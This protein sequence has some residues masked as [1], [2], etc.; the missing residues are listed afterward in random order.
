MVKLL[1][2]VARSVRGSLWTLGLSSLLAVGCGGDAKPPAAAPG[3]AQPGATGAPAAHADAHHHDHDLPSG[4]VPSPKLIDRRARNAV[5]S[6]S[7][8]VARSAA[9]PPKTEEE[10]YRAVAPATVIVRVP[11]GLGSGVIIDPAG[12][13]LTNHHVVEHGTSE[14]FRT[15]VGIVLGHLDKST[16]GMERDKKEYT[17]WV[18]KDDKLRDLALVK[19]ENP[20]KNL[21]FVPLSKTPPVPGEHVIAIGHAGAGM[22]WAIK[23]GEISALGKLSEHLATLAQFKDDDSGKKAEAEFKKYLDGQNLGLVIQST[24]N[25]LPGDSGGPLVTQ[26]GELVGL[27]AFSN[28]DPRTGG[29]LNFHIHLQEI[30]KFVKQ[31]PAKVAR[32]IPDPWTEGGGDASYEDVDLNGKVDTLLLQGRRACT[33]CPRQSVAVFIDPDEDMAGK[34]P[35]LTDVFEKKSFGGD[36]VY[37]QLESTSYIWYDTDEDGHPDILLV[38]DSTTGRSSAAYRIQ[39]D[40][41]IV[42]DPKLASGPVIRMSLFK[43]Q[44]TRERLQRIAM[45]AFPDSYVEAAT[46]LAETLPQPVG[47]T[48]EA[49]TADLDG[50]GTKDSVRINSTFSARVVVDADENSV[51]SLPAEFDV[52]KT[53]KPGNL[54]SEVSVVSQSTH[55]WV[56]YDTDNDGRYDLVLHAPGSRLYVATEAFHVDA[57]G[58]R[59]DAPEDVGRKLMRPELLGALGPRMHKIADKSF[60]DIL[61]AG[62]DSGLASFP[63]PVSDHRGTSMSLL[64]E[65][66]SPHAVIA[67]HGYGSDGYLVDLDQNSLRGKKTKGLDLGKLARDGKIDAEFAYFQR[68]GLAWAYYD[69]DNKDGYDTVL[70]SADPHGG[71]VDRA[72]HV[73]KNGATLDA[74]LA[75]GPLVR[76]S[77]FKSK[78]LSGKLKKLAG[79]LF[80]DAAIEK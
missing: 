17:A 44:E 22:L 60:L 69:T 55:M 50:D 58:N 74:S 29:L 30:S 41:D 39:P 18:Y 14:D 80:S 78:T 15:K 51:P 16:G 2:S 63:D 66:G 79:E 34:L 10:V 9:R 48:G 77:L 52:S 43:D 26:R 33:Y 6:D 46:P 73:D 59:T 45:A 70:Y 65:K 67:V 20:P 49:I 72:Y 28:K 8:G 7:L 11:D 54:D 23:A 5:A 61:T 64:A 76:P 31:K 24:C 19:I 27:N 75:G 56:W 62:N 21:P 68:N 42:K 25:I 40:G 57:S 4:R 37:L 36:L 13:V 12:W 1:G 47:P 32:L 53:I 35:S 71:K 38:D 3:A